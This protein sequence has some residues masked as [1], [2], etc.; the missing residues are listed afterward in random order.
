MNA[1]EGAALSAKRDLDLIIVHAWHG[2]VFDRQKRLKKL[3]H[4]LQSTPE[5]AQTPPEMLEVLR[6][7]KGRGAA[8]K[9]T[10]VL[11]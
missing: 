10:R 7:F 6:Q 5:K 9:I 1:M 4:Y 11:H 8:M 3:S 2:V